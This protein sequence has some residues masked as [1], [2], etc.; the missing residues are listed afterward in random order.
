MQKTVEKKTNY[1]NPCS[2]MCKHGVGE[3]IKNYLVPLL[4]ISPQRCPRVLGGGLLG[5]CG[6]GMA[7]R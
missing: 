7:Q 4:F 6:C 3:E 1:G 5:C 2:V